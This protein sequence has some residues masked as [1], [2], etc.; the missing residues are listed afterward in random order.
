MKSMIGGDHVGE[1]RSAAR[2]F[3]DHVHFLE[4][5]QTKYLAVLGGDY[6]GERQ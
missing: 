5:P 2:V 6:E 3:T 4:K 1:W